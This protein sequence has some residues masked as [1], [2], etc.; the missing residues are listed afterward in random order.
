M[1]ARCDRA[2]TLVR[3]GDDATAR[4]VISTVLLKGQ[5]SKAIHSVTHKETSKQTWMMKKKKK[6]KNSFKR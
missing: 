1:E 6:K 4:S 2:Y 5:L 3:D